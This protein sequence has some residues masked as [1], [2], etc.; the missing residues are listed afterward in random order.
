MM[1]ARCSATPPL[2]VDV[3]TDAPLVRADPRLLRHMLLDLL[4]NAERHGGKRVTIDV[5]RKPDTVELRVGDDGAGLSDDPGMVFSAFVQGT[6]TDRRGGSGL[7][8][9]IVKGFANAMGLQ[10][11]ARAD[12]LAGTTFSITF[13]LLSDDGP[14]R[15]T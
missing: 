1:C 7:G 6:G 8:L 10:V 13:P 4:S 12:T 11:A 3:P 2:R 5:R 15:R 14:S 9:A